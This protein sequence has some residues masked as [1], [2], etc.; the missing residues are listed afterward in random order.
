[1]F[2]TTTNFAKNN[3]MTYKKIYTSLF[4]L[5]LITSF[6]GF[7]QQKTSKPKLVVGVVVDQMR[8]DYLTRFYERFGNDGFRRLVEKGFNAENNHFNYIPTYT[9]PGHA[10]VYTGTSPAHHGIIGNSWYDKSSKTSVYCVSDTLYQTVGSATKAGQMSPHRLLTSTVTDQ[11]RLH[12]QQ[13]GKVV[14]VGIKDRGAV[15]PAGFSGTA[16]WFDGG[17][18]GKWISSTYY[19]DKLPNWVEK[20][21][22]SGKVKAYLKPWTTLYD[23]KTYVESG[24][25]DNNYEGKFKGETKAIFPHDLP[26]LNKENE[27]YELVKSSAF[28]NDITKDFA[29]AVLKNEQMG[30]DD[31]TDFLAISFSSTD[32]L[33]HMYG[34]NSVEVQDAYLRLDQ[35]IAE[36]LNTLDKEV[37]VGNYTVFLTADHGA[38]HV[39]AYLQDQKMAA[40]YFNNDEFVGEVKYYANEAFGSDKVIEKINNQQIFLNEK[41]IDSLDLDVDDVEEAL[42]Q[43]IVKLP[44]VLEA[45]TATSMRNATFTEGTPALMQ[46]GYNQK[47][48]GHVLYTLHPGFIS[49]PKVGST[50]GSGYTYDTHVPLIFFGWGIE[51][52]KTAM[53]TNITDIAPTIAALLGIS[54]PN[55]ASGNVLDFVLKK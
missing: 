36:I 28:G 16:Y 27:T 18:Q 35:N 22:N 17:E 38:V 44:S 47:R 45:Y 1:M 14:G 6:S 10:S 26:A 9:A 15:L 20:Y 48:S 30:K 39:P 8:Y 41:S 31:V 19:M 21:N 40:G 33:G 37:G 54:P 24:P 23:I 52:G 32:Y 4:C 42:A 11:L 49:Y 46:R 53:R 2:L 29:L 25:D 34:V 7:A 55:Y 50:H 43:Y 51:P 12:T 13:R 3:Q 5:M